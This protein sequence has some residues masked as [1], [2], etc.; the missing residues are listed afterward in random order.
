MSITDGMGASPTAAS[1]P[2]RDALR[3]VRPRSRQFYNAGVEKEIVEQAGEAKAKVLLP[4][5]AGPSIAIT[6]GAVGDPTPGCLG[7]GT[8]SSQS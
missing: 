3:E 6:A 7:D 5:A 4:E 2:H 8:A 1:S